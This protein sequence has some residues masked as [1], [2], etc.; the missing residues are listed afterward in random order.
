MKRSLAIQVIRSIMSE[1]HPLTDSEGCSYTAEEIL[2]S[3]QKIGMLPPKAIF[4][5]SVRV[6]DEERTAYRS[7]NEWEDE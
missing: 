1:N 7:A 3:L 2:S 6:G 4:S 5:H